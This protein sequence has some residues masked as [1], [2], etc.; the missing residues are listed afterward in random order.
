MKA[1]Y[2]TRETGPEGLTFG[3]VPNPRPKAGEVLIEVHAAGVTPSELSWFP[4]FKTS[5]GEP[6]SFPVILSHEF[7]GIVRQV[8]NGVSGVAVGDAV[9][10][11][12]DWFANGALAEYCVASAAAISVKPKTID[13]TVAAVV[14]I[15]ALTAWQGLFDRCRLR[16]GERV[17]VHGGAGGVGLFAVQL[18]RWRGAYVLATASGPNLDFVR[19]LGADEVIDYKKT[20]FETCARDID[21][22]FDTV[23]EETLERSWQVLRPG[24]R[25]TTIATASGASAD[26]RVREA[27]FIVEPKQDQLAEV[28]R[29]IE[30][31][32]LRA[33]VE[34]VY[35]WEQ[36][37][38]AFARAS[39]GGMRGK[40]ALRIKEE[41]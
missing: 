31:G 8:G 33:F 30:G 2:L 18:A 11:M 34:A 28:S 22:V 29:L 10:G 27:F 7:S 1:V 13:D 38:E 32:I 5:T 16:P 37:R 6:R 9:Y 39:R 4:T 15:S 35:G 40:V 12:N 24:G 26:P 17:L 25:L 14:P 19:Q 23:G 3:E 20:Q 41:H 21:L 36:A